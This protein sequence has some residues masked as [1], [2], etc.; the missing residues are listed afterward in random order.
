MTWLLIVGAAWLA[1]AAVLARVIARAIQVA[2]R[3]QRE[4]A[5]SVERLPS[6]DLVLLGHPDGSV[7]L[8]SPEAP[9]ADPT[10]AHERS[11]H[12][13]TPGNS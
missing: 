6:G 4:T 2:E 13:R 12:T 1:I 11:P 5:D 9:A 3:R 7:T 8:L 10:R